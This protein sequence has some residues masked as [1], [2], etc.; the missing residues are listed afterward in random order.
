MQAL[1]VH[2]D[3]AEIDR[4]R[5][6]LSRRGFMVSHCQNQSEG[7]QF[8]RS[9][10]TDLLV[11]KQV[12]DS[13]HTTSVALAAEHHHPRAATILL[14][15]RQRADAV[16]LFE[17]IPSLQAVLGPRPDDQTIGSLA[18]SAVQDASQP[19]LVLTAKDKVSE[20]ANELSVPAAVSTPPP[21]PIAF[22]TS[23]HAAA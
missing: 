13:K 10:V 2:D 20:P 12:I 6:G 22:V 16:E 17:L 7:L 14:S 15:D 11:L 5:T 23:K 19:V 18:L 8:V 21:G 3:P 9:A 1:I 4:L